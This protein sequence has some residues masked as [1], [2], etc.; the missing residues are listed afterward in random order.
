MINL[1]A[2]SNVN[3][4]AWTSEFLDPKLVLF[5]WA[6]ALSSR[7]RS[8]SLI[9]MELVLRV[10]LQIV[11]DKRIFPTG[12]LASSLLTHHISAL[13]LHKVQGLLLSHSLGKVQIFF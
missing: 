12:E 6:V 7:C 13:S 9:S 5:H 4:R 11:P 8:K 3:T 1:K 2:V 10:F